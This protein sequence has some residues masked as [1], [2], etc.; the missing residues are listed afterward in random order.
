MAGMIVTIDGPAAAGKSTA[1]KALAERIAFDYLDTGAM[2][3]AVTLVAL[4]RGT[5]L[6]REDALAEL[7]AELRIMLRGRRVL[8]DGEDVTEAIRD[9]AVTRASAR[10]ADSPAVR[11]R[12]VE[13]QREAAR[14]QNI[15]SE[16]RDQGTIVFPDADCKIFL[17][18]RADVRAERRYREFLARGQSCTLEQVLTDQAERDRRD[19]TRAIAP[20]VP[21]PDA[22]VLDSS[23]MPFR[24]VVDVLERHVR[25]AERRQGRPKDN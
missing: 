23:T 15:V 3:R 13:L 25:A 14:G 20:M 17:P 7:S 4:R 19:A 24:E 2:Y 11:R 6:D 12:M 9:I 10:V 5:A 21:A 1:A 16:G 8:L 22:I 18:A